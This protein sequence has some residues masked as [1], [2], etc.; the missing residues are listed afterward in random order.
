MCDPGLSTFF[1]LS[2]ALPVNISLGCKDLSCTNISS[3]AQDV[4]KEE[5]S[6]IPFMKNTYC[7]FQVK[8]ITQYTNVQHIIITQI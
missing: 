6:F 1:R 5:K 8:F 2:L 7:L 4:S 3:L